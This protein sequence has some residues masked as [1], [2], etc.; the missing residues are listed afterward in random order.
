MKKILLLILLPLIFSFSYAKNDSLENVIEIQVQ[1]FKNILEVVSANYYKENIDISKISENAFNSLLQSLDKFSTYFNASQYEKIKDAFKG[2]GEGIGVQ[3]FRRGDSLMVFNVLKGSPADSVGLTVGDRIIYINHEYFV[4]KDAQSAY[5]KISESQNKKC[6]L[7]IKRGGFLKEVE[8]PIAETQIPSVVVSVEFKGTSVG[9]LKLTRFSLSTFSEFT[10]AFDSLVKIGCKRFIIDLR[11][12]QGGYLDETVKLVELFLKKGDTIVVVSGREVHRKVYIC[13][14]DGKYKKYPLIVLVD[15]NSAS[16]SEIF[17]SAMQDNDRA[18]VVGERTFGKGLVQRTWE[19]KDGSAF[20]LTTGEYVSP[21]G[22]NIQ[23]PEVEN[24]DL[25]AFADLTL[26]KEQKE[27]IEE[28][29]KKTGGATNLPIYYTKKG[30]ALFGGGAVVPDYFFQYDTLPPYLNK[31]KNNGLLNDFVLR[32]FFD[33]QQNYLEISKL[34]FQNFL[35]K[36]EV[37]DRVMSS[38]K[39]YLMQTNS[40]LEKYFDEEYY[41]IKSEIKAT[42]GYILFGD[43]GYFS[44]LLLQDTIIGKVQNLFGEAEK[45]V[46]Q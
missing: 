15:K 17:A 6:I 13:E 36:F 26:G 33:N 24:V 10:R 34:N 37:S 39:Q 3:F 42:L 9:L 11:G 45:L 43:S 32:Y 35:F 29:I 1:K 27:M 22:R 25:G 44:T 20:R 21:L 12:N 5:R 30:R 2:S 18:I 19:F 38:F 4:G 7:T 14:K 46:Q 8:V 31:L 16:A 40:Y 23:K 28:L 41:R